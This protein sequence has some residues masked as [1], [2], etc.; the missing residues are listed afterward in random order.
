MQKP[1]LTEMKCKIAESK[2]SDTISLSLLLDITL[3]VTVSDNPVA[4]PY[5][6]EMQDRGIKWLRHHKF[7]A[8]FRHY[9]DSDGIW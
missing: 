2:G 7:V 9:I 1:D 4:R 6:N 5:R 8:G 3:T